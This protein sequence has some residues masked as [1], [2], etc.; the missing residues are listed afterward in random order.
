MVG[1]VP[2]TVRAGDQ[3][4]WV[5]GG[6]DEGGR[7]QRRGKPPNPAWEEEGPFLQDRAPE[8]RLAG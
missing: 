6:G 2:G 8:L 7:A 4:T 3:D 1:A 5:L